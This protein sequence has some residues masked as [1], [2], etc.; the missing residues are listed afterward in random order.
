MFQPQPAGGVFAEDTVGVG[1]GL[2][3]FGLDKRADCRGVA[4][5]VVCGLLAR[6]GSARRAG[7]L[8]APDGEAELI[9]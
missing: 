7:F 5:S 2:E 1:L 3:A 9:Y 6:G 4:E 8:T